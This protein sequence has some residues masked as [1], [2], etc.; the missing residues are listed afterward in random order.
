MAFVFNNKESLYEE[1]IKEFNYHD[2]TENDRGQGTLEGKRNE[3]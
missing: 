2:R 1:Q 3:R